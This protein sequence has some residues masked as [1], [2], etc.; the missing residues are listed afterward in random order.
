M[1]DNNKQIVVFWDNILGDVEKMKQLIPFIHVLDPS[2][3]VVLKQL[4]EHQPDRVKIKSWGKLKELGT[5]DNI[6]SFYADGGDYYPLFL[7]TT[8]DEQQRLGFSYLYA[9]Y[10]DIM[11]YLLE[12]FQDESMN[13]VLSNAR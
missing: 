10:S 4:N 5:L 1:S 7:Y 3:E 12:R 11:W 2:E 9:D 8:S 13:K 6:N